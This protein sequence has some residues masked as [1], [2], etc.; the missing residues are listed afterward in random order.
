MSILVRDRLS[1]E[2]HLVIP[3]HISHFA[4]VTLWFAVT[5]TQFKFDELILY[6]LALFFGYSFIREFRDLAPL[7]KRSFVLFIFPVWC[8]LS[9]IWAGEPFLAVKSG[10]QLVLTVM[11]CFYVAYHMTPR[12]VVLAVLIAS[13]IFGVLSFLQSF[14]GGVAA[15]GVFQSKNTMGFA[16]LVMWMSA[17]TVMLDAER[18]WKL[19]ILA[20]AAS[21]LAVHQ[22][23]TANSATATIL[24]LLLGAIAFTGLVLLRGGTLFRGDRIAAVC[25]ILFA[26]FAS[27]SAVVA[28]SE[29]DPVGDVLEAF[30]KDRTLTG[31]TVLWQYA[32]RE[33]AERPFLGV[34]N[35]GF[36]LPYDESPTVR[37]IFVEFDKT[38]HATFSFHN[39]FYE[40]AVHQGLI[41]AGLALIPV[42][43]AAVKI[44]RWTLTRGEMPALFFFGIMAVVL[45]R[46]YTESTLMNTF[47]QLTMLFYIGAL[48]VV[49]NQFP[50]GET[51]KRGNYATNQR[52]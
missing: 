10:L 40:I 4:I 52:N 23:L 21:V 17:I 14:S 24:M 35:G 34:G 42:L 46:T 26:I 51:N 45:A 6:P 19:R 29:V 20:G 36:W 5:F 2:H 38:K 43:W 18:A 47:E 33:I 7:L 49:Q 25:L 27:L 3:S 8:L 30:G 44:T 41:G 48:F 1:G 50:A 12:Q 13:S 31:R 28:V 11:I 39:S 16:M 37:R 15:R 9:V 32:E 22:V